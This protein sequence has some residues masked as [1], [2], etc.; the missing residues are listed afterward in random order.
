MKLSNISA[1][2][3][4]F[5]GALL[6][7]YTVIW[8]VLVYLPIATL[9]LVKCYQVIVQEAADKQYHGLLPSINLFILV[10]VVE[11]SLAVYGMTLWSYY[12][13]FYLICAA[14]YLVI[15]LDKI[16]SKKVSD[17]SIILMITSCIC[18][19]FFC[20]YPEEVAPFS[21]T[22]WLL[23]AVS[24]YFTFTNQLLREVS[25]T[26]PQVF[27]VE[28]S[29]WLL[30]IYSLFRLVSE[31][32]EVD[33]QLSLIFY[34]GA[35]VLFLMMAYVIM[36]QYKQ[37]KNSLKIANVG[38]CLLISILGIEHYYYYASL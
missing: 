2:N 22:I 14:S 30:F 3:L 4:M 23:I 17:E 9:L 13:S 7:T 29:Q 25:L 27:I 16:L 26:T 12:T 6:I 15:K 20:C 38:A 21:L 32:F 5:F 24:L 31:V 1:L 10:A 28:Q 11:R 19:L 8:E 33:F 35:L 36:K 18:L 37:L 34:A